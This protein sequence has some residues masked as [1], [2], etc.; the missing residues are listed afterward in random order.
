M[1]KKSTHD[2]ARQFFAEARKKPLDPVYLFSGDERFL[3]DR[4]VE[5]VV[6]VLFGRSEPDPFRY[7]L[8]RAAEAGAQAVIASARMSSLIGGQRLLLVRDAELFKD[9]DLEM[10]AEYAK[11]PSTSCNLVLVVSASGKID[12]RKKH[13][14]TLK[15]NVTEIVFDPL[16]DEQM[17]DWIL[18]QAK[19]RHLDL[20]ED[21]AQY[22]ASAL[23][24]DMAICD[25]AL[26]KVS[27]ST[28]PRKQIYLAD[29]ENLVAHTR[30][31]SVFEL[32]R[33]VSQRD[34]SKSLLALHQLLSQ[35]EAAI[36]VSFM[37]TRELR[38]ILRLKAALQDGTSHNELPSLLGVS[39]FAIKDYLRAADR[40]NMRELV[41]A[42]HMAFEIDWRLKS[43][44]L[45][46]ELIIEPLLWSICRP[47][48]APAI[49]AD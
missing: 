9:S 21:A 7:E 19:R 24:A 47:P 15:Q 3:I 41:Q 2:V 31:H 39:P 37:I 36:K 42:M 40:F 44:R 13:W 5:E 45:P 46:P 22:L 8:L 35:G 29:V 1:A 28:S 14:K 48:A 25:L 30:E 12:G 26:E 34:L 32:T 4:A 33:A 11:K 27:L 17:P 23:G 49:N 43:S 38:M 10:L 18:R 20:A 16:R 6:F